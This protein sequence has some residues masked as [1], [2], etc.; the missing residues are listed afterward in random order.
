VNI[1][2]ELNLI[3]PGAIPLWLDLGAVALGAIYGA[4]L[5]TSRN[6]P[7]I[8]V[9]LVSVL[10]GFG[11]SMLRDIMLNTSINA[12]THGRY[13]TTVMVCTILGALIGNRLLQP[14]WLILMLDALV[15]GLFVVIG[16]EKAYLFGMP[17]S[18]SIFIGTITAIGGGILADLLLGQRP[19]IMSRGPWS[20]SIALVCACWF[21]LA[22]SQGWRGFAEVSSIAL[23]VLL[24]GMV[25]WRGWEAPMPE[26][27][28]SVDWIRGRAR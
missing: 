20:A 26:H 9:L 6:A 2:T 14:K 5:A 12:L 13:M 4:T 24:K 7:L 18:S 21:V 10:M 17:T 15:M 16:T 25:L 19:D 3:E 22:Y 8:G 27:L 1:A 23:A 11:G 28:K